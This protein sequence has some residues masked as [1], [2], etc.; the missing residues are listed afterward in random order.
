MARVPVRIVG[1]NLPGLR[2]DCYEPVYVAS[3]RIGEEVE[4]VYPADSEQIVVDLYVDVRPDRA[5]NLDYRGPY[6]GG[7]RKGDR[8][9]Y[10]SWGTLSHGGSFE[11]FRAAKL[12]L[13]AIDHAELDRVVAASLTLQAT[14]D[15]TDSRGGP[16]CARVPPENITW[17]FVPTGSG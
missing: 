8:S 16:I 2:F 17:E 11:T 4:Q 10:L 15:L 13:P 1:R 14:V 6:V 5:G 7:G 3:S 12:R 9:V